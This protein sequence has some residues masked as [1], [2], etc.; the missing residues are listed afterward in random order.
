MNCLFSYCSL[1]ICCWTRFWYFF[2]F[3]CLLATI[4]TFLYH[5][6]SILL[7][8]NL[9]EYYLKVDSIMSP[10]KFLGFLII[11]N[12]PSSG[13][14]PTILSNY[15]SLAI[16]SYEC[17]SIRYLFSHP[18]VLFFLRHSPIKIALG[19]STKSSRMNSSCRFG[20]TSLLM[21]GPCVFFFKLWLSGQLIPLLFS[22]DY[23]N[24]INAKFIISTM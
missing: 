24:L 7:L 13:I 19:G 6:T 16:S 15:K 18:M 4:W 20:C 23:L 12:P 1:S 22:I 9:K 17:P 5:S 3:T 14:T 8:S 2:T 10:P 21:F 11:Q